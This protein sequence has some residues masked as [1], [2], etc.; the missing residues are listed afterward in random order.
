[1]NIHQELKLW[2]RRRD[3]ELNA[4]AARALDA[5]AARPAVVEEA[6]QAWERIGSRLR[7]QPIPTPPADAM[8]QDVRRAIHLLK[9]QQTEAARARFR[10]DW[11]TV[12][13]TASLVLGVGFFGV[14]LLAPPT[15]QAVPRVEWVEAAL[16]GA[17]AMV[18]E[19]AKSG[20]VVIWLFA[21]ENG[22]MN[23]SAP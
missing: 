7:G 23:G 6:V 3:G 19:D 16:P 21:P 17:G 5:H 18:Y 11:A 10:W 22:P 20:A 13:A 2:S 12:A 4:R 14:R 1:M 8:W 15:A 9:A